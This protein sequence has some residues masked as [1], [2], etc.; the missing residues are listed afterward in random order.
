VS[1]RKPKPKA[2][3]KAKKGKPKVKAS[4]SSARPTVVI[5]LPPPSPAKGKQDIP[6]GLRFEVIA[7]DNSTCQLCGARPPDVVLH[8][9]HIV[10]ESM[11]GAMDLAN[12]RTLCEA[13]NKGRGNTPPT[14]AEAAAVAGAQAAIES[15]LSSK[16]HGTPLKESHRRFV[17]AYMSNGGVGVEAARAAGY[18][19]DNAAL[20]TRASE[21]LG[22][23]DVQAAMHERVEADPTVV[24]RKERQR[25][26]SS[27]M[28][29]VDANGATLKIPLKERIEASKLLARAQ[30]DFVE[31]KVITHEGNVFIAL[32]D[33]GR[34]DGPAP[35]ELPLD[36]EGDVDDAST[37]G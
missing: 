3:A 28:R 18:S 31:R 15:A 10:P 30:G 2:R 26:W 16:S 35:R 32:P 22:R 27:V 5:A 1:R 24:D 21:L 23:E 34:G 14:A 11:G 13:C 29:G 17:E 7:R 25:W 19:G 8:V 20:A 12:L 36:D 9:D 37:E 33:N 6:K 4:T